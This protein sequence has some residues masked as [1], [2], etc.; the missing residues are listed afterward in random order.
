MRITHSLLKPRKFIKALPQTGQLGR[1]QDANPG[2]ITVKPYPLSD[3]SLGLSIWER[4][5]YSYR[6]RTGSAG[7]KHPSPSQPL[8]SYSLPCHSHLQLCR[9]HRH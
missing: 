5:C 8:P 3:S 9:N 7:L 1:D 4:S 6:F 2:G